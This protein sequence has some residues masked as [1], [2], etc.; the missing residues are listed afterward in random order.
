M[1]REGM[2]IGT[3]L[4]NANGT[5]TFNRINS[6]YLGKVYKPDFCIETLIAGEPGMASYVSAAYLL[7]D[8]PRNR[9]RR[10]L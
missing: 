6:L 7:T 4:V 10:M 8:S 1:L 3:K 5:W 2:W 9:M